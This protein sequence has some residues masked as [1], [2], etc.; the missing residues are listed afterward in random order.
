MT[1]SVSCPSCSS[2]FR[3]D[4]A[5]IGKKARC[6]KCSAVLTVTPSDDDLYELDTPAAPPSASP[7]WQED[8][9]EVAA[10][11]LPSAYA[12]VAIPVSVPLP[13]L[14]DRS[15]PTEPWYYQFLVGYAWTVAVLGLLQLLY[16][17]MKLVEQYEK[18]GD[19]ELASDLFWRGATSVMTIAACIMIGALLVSAPVLVFVDIARNVRAM[20]YE[21]S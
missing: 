18:L 7:S 9:Q 12:P 14:A 11:P 13:P 16:F 10:E 2:K 6:K 8:D 3:T 5:H 19:T 1:I 20:R 21:R 4:A 17:A 15:M